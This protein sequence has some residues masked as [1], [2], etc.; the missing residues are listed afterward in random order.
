MKNAL[1]LLTLS[2][3]SIF[4][5]AQTVF[6]ANDL[7]QIGD[8]LY[9]A[10]D[11]DYPL[12]N[13][14][15]KGAG[16]EWDF[17]DL[18]P[19]DLALNVY[20]DPLETPFSSDFPAANI[21]LRIDF[22][23]PSYSYF[24]QNDSIVD[25]LGLTANIE[26]F[27]GLQLLQFINPQLF[28]VLPTNLGSNFTDTSTF[29]FEFQEPVFNQTIK[30][31]STT[32]SQINTDAS[33]T[34]KTP[35]GNFDALLQQVVTERRDS[36]FTF[37]FGSEILVENLVELDTILLWLAPD[38]K[39]IL[40]STDANNNITY[41]APD[42]ADL[43]APVAGFNYLLLTSSTD[44]IYFIDESAN[45]PF[46]WNWDFGDGNTSTERNPSHRFDTTGTFNVCLTVENSAGSNQVCE[47]ISITPTSTRV[48]ANLVPLEVF[49]NPANQEIRFKT[50]N[51]Q[52]HDS[53]LTIFNQTGQ[54]VHRQIF[55]LDQQI[56]T[57]N[58]PVGLYYYHLN[59]TGQLRSSGRFSIVR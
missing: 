29:E 5:F 50:K 33:G 32:Y 23:E 2:S 57:Q 21:A 15:T 10:I 18:Y 58:W 43:Q 28:T 40:L 47:L 6:T 37:L 35:G 49:P 16:L 46:R 4:S 20:L 52:L 51:D 42:L 55:Q 41:Y 3:Y 31:R 27:G 26:D 9:F 12:R 56:I 22:D 24:L 44:S 53:Q 11:N 14:Q 30:L 34:V 8:T 45:T 1:L 7:P 25:I 39:G 59:Q 17:T 48:R 13:L 19:N 38:S 36:L 54:I